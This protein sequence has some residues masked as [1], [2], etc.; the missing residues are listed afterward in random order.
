MTNNVSQTI[1]QIALPLICFG[2]PGLLFMLN[3]IRII[4]NKK[5][6]SIGTD[7]SF[8]WREPVVITG[9]KAVEAGKVGIILG[10]ILISLG[11]CPV[12]GLLLF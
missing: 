4:R 11:I 6:I 7:S 2:L 12:A 1:E 8:R 10:I 5:T 9:N 3:G